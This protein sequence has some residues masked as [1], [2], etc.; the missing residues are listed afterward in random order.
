MSILNRSGV[1][2]IICRMKGKGGVEPLEAIPAWVC[3]Q[4]GEPYFE[5]QEV[6][7]IQ[8]LLQRLDKETANLASVA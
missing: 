8:R 3:G 1:G 5:A 6:K 7:L 4:C 2:I